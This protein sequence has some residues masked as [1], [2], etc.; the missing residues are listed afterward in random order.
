MTTPPTLTNSE[1]LASIFDLDPDES[2]WTCHFTA[3]PSPKAPWAGRR[4]SP[5]QPAPDL[6][7]QNAY[8]AVASLRAVDGQTRR[9]LK[10]FSRLW[11][12]VLDDAPETLPLQPTWIIETSRPDGRPKIQVGYRLSPPV[13]DIDLAR[14]AHHA[15]ARA[16]HVGADANG[17]NPVR[18]VR[19]PIGANTKHTPA[20][21][22][23]LIAWHPDRRYDLETI[24]RAY[25]LDL[26][27]PKK[28]PA[29]AAADDSSRSFFAR[30]NERALGT[31]PAWVPAIFGTAATA[32]QAGYRI[33]S[34]ALKRDLQED[35]SIMPH[36]IMDF[37]LEMGLT[38][39][40]VVIRHGPER[41]T[42]A[43]ALWLCRQIGADP[44]ALGWRIKEH[45]RVVPIETRKHT[46]TTTAPGL[47]LTD[48][49]GE[50]AAPGDSEPY[51]VAS[52]PDI[53][54]HA[55]E[56]YARF[57]RQPLPLVG[58]SALAQMALA[59]QGLADV[60]RDGQLRSGL[61]LYIMV[62]AIS[63]ERK[64]AADRQFSRAARAWI[65][66]AR[67]DRLPAHQR[68]LAMAT[69]HRAR[70][71]GIEA[72]IK[73][74]ASKDLGKDTDAEEELHRLRERLIELKQNPIIVTP[75]PFHSYEDVNAA[76]LAYALGS[77]WPSGALLSDEAGAVIGS[78]GLA[79]EGAT[80]LLALLNILWDGRE[81]LPTR[82]QA[83]VAEL[84][85][86][87]FSTFLQM[88]PH[89]LS[90]LLEKDARSLG[91]LARFLISHPPS[92]MG[93]RLYQEPP[94]HWSALD[95]FDARITDLLE[96]DLPIDRSG[97]DRGLLMR[98]DPPVMRLA[99]AAKA[100]W[101]EF[102]DAIERELRPF[103]EFAETADIASKTAENAARI[104]GVFQ[105]FDRGG[106]AREIEPRWMQAGIALAGWHLIEARRILNDLDAPMPIQDARLLRDWLTG[107]ALDAANG[108]GEPIMDH[109]TGIIE[110]REVS[111]LGP[112]R[113][114]DVARRDA[115]IEH[116]VDARVVRR[117]NHG[118]RRLI[119]LNGHLLAARSVAT[120]ARKQAPTAVSGF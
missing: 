116:L 89:L 93:T 32:Y 105:V 109:T 5:G 53:A 115:A 84:R 20:H 38:P 92:T 34:K 74:L 75:L 55:V 61:G 79:E 98:L 62:L 15:L 47:W 21:P 39:I 68:S 33:T 94:E 118:K 24:A 35:L 19:L 69:D 111:R 16:G 65:R 102:H 6:P 7:E 18:Y 103:G 43:A 54:R 63:G 108:D 82:K 1:F 11:A 27:P 113:L 97:S 25:Q 44:T 85:G 30:V 99:P 8:F 37:G 80:G 4:L 31:L 41:E 3:P 29:P 36:G 78:Q 51:P 14:R 110:T 95:A 13:D 96:H 100:A 48:E 112:N 70:E 17:N 22:H 52:F 76:S 42:A 117:I 106:A 90:R 60:A 86:R 119:Q 9:T 49:P 101:I 83:A 58:S 45:S 71:T 64:S 91:F 26:D 114:R 28:Q 46:E 81:F 107:R 72:R 88:Q 104:A 57:G 12:I 2:I 50:I 23:R 66:R 10:H 59:A 67:E 40:D 77:G 56:E 87:R 120:D 73:T